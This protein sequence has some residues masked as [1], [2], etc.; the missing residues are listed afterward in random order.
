MPAENYQIGIYTARMLEQLKTGQYVRADSSYD[1]LLRE[2]QTGQNRGKDIRYVE[3]ELG[4]LLRD[5][6]KEGPE[7]DK[8]RREI[9]KFLD[10]LPKASPETSVPARE[11]H[12]LLPNR[13]SLADLERLLILS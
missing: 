6:R 11:V 10:Q 8:L 3:K 12:R 2:I 9:A 4:G 13:V 1:A 5:S 7:A